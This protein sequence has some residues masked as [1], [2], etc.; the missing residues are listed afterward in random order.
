MGSG[1][2]L[3]LRWFAFVHGHNLVYNACWEDPRLDRVALELGPED[4]VA[5]I[6]SAGCNVLDYALVGPRHIY[7]VDMNPRQNALLELKIAGIRHLDFDTF[8]EMFGRGRLPNYRQVYRDHLRPALSPF[9]AEYWDR[10]IRF[11]APGGWRNSFYFHGSSGT[12][13]R[14]VNFYIDRIVRV[15]DAV[16]RLLAATSLDQQQTIYFGELR[17]AVW[18][19]FVRWLL[20]HDT[21]LS[22]VG[23]PRPQRQQV[24]RYYR[25]GIAQYVEDCVEAV[26]ACLPIWDNYFWR[27]Y[28]TGEYSPTCCPEYL[29]PENFARLR[30]GLVDRISIHTGSLREF[31][32]NH[33]GTISRFVLLDHMDWLCS[34]HYPELE[35]EWQAIVRRAASQA[36]IL[37]RSGGLK[38]EYVDPIKVA[39]QGRS[40]KV[41]DLLRYHHDLAAELHAK[42]R[43]HTYGSFYI[44]D[45]ALA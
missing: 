33:D 37:W 20:G 41:G 7:A 12:F 32:E 29:K 2:W 21:T 34:Y 44:A 13:A 4:T 26:F 11:F 8:F 23:V 30:A 27:V 45:L 9:A 25:G 42:D 36:R 22:F 18:R 43:V 16:S 24:E 10:H 35:R 39:V 31:L 14:L 28:L 1:D 17:D 40:Y 5:V 3:S 15:R 19:R 6:T 38:V